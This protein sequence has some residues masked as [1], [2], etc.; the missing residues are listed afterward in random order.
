[1]ANKADPDQI[2]P[3]NVGSFRQAYK[4]QYY[5][6]SSYRTRPIE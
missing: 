1:M 3:D 4:L 6:R 5:T 2:V